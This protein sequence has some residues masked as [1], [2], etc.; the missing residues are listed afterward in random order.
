MESYFK[1]LFNNNKMN[2]LYLTETIRS[3]KESDDFSFEYDNY[4]LYERDKIFGTA[5]Y[6]INK[7]SAKIML[8]YVYQY[9]IYYHLDVMLLNMPLKRLSIT[10]Q[11]VDNLGEKDSTF[12]NHSNKLFLKAVSKLHGPSYYNLTF[13]LFGILNVFTIN[14]YFLLMTFL[15]V[16][17]I[18]LGITNWFFWFV[19]GLF[20]YEALNI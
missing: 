20:Y 5:G 18:I 13:P 6:C 10:P 15:F 11:L 2:I 4:K 17:F 12:V 8:K 1:Q 9:K 19:F 7:R 14:I 3:G 16:V